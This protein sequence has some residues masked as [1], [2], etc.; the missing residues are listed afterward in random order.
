MRYQSG[1]KAECINW[2]SSDLKNFCSAKDT[3]KRMKRQ[4][5]DCEKISANHTSDKGLVSGIKNSQNS[6]LNNKQYN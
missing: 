2:T 1:K 4:I 6:S 3:I 5:I